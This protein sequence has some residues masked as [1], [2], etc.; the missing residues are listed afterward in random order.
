MLNS[1]TWIGNSRVTK[2]PA[3]M[4]LTVIDLPPHAFQ[5]FRGLVEPSA[6]GFL[7]HQTIP[8]N[9]AS[10]ADTLRRKN[11]P[12]PQPDHAVS[13]A[14]DFT[15]GGSSGRDH[16][17]HRRSSHDSNPRSAS[18]CRPGVSAASRHSILLIFFCSRCDGSPFFCGPAG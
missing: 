9:Y 12:L 4:S 1:S 11:V 8:E 14:R 6:G 3:W 16:P 17:R 5:S 15:E 18:L 7:F 2:S 13:R 10:I